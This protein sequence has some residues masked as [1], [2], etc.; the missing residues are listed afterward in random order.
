RL[1]RNAVARVNISHLPFADDDEWFLMNAVLPWVQSKVNAA[2]QK[3][4][5]ETGFAIARDDLALFKRAFAAPD[6]FNHTD[7]RVRDINDPQQSRQ[8]KQQN[9]Q[10]DCPGDRVPGRVVKLARSSRGFIA[11]FLLEVVSLSE[12]FLFLNA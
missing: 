7:V 3:P 12:L 10:R 6:F 1:Q 5:L 9:Y 4:R 8:T 2:T 11:L